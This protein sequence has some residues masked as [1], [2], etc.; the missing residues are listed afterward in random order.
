M[1]VEAQ[2]KTAWIG[3]A[4]ERYEQPL[5]RYAAGI[6]GD[7]EL[8]RDVVQDTFLQLC[9]AE[10]VRIE[11]HMAA[12]LYTVCRN[13][14]LNVRKKEGR[15]NP[16]REGQAETLPNGSA[17]PSALAERNEAHHLVLDAIGA[18]PPKQQEACR[19]KFQDELTY[20]EI[21]QIM[22]VSLG[23]VSNL[24]TNA[25]DTIR[26]RLQADTGLAQEG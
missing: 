11:D 5:L 9:T 6:A 15:M 22:G 1:Q 25:L 16:L 8:A 21:S 17:G 7:A 26:Q 13:R 12:W 14:A 24:V 20:R 10:Q 18:L 23:T 19:L 3:A 4:L 2:S